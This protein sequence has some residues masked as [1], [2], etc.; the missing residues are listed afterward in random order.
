MTINKTPN[1]ATQQCCGQ[2]KY[3]ADLFYNTDGTD[4]TV[5]VCGQCGLCD[6]AK[7]QEQS[8]AHL[9]GGSLIPEWN[10][11]TPLSLGS[12]YNNIN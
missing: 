7:A 4:K 11:D 12:Q 1:Q 5:N 2:L 10:S 3:Q 8:E 6:N 9:I